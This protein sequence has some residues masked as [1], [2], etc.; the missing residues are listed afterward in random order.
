MG[1]VR[2]QKPRHLN[3]ASVK[4]KGFKCVASSDHVFGVFIIPSFSCTNQILC[5]LGETTIKC[6][7]AKLWMAGETVIPQR[8]TH[9]N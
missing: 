1:K 5:P 9:G 4:F 6:I 7:Y 8:H 2:S 3:R